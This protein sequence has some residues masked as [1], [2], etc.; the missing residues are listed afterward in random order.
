MIDDLISFEAWC[1][2]SGVKSQDPDEAPDWTAGSECLAWGWYLGLKTVYQID[3][4]RC[5]PEC[6]AAAFDHRTRRYL[7]WG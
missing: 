5:E 7:P 6:K 2:V 3:K 4:L 1:A